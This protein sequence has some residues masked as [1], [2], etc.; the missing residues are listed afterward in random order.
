MTDQTILAD[1]VRDLHR[2]ADKVL[3]NTDSQHCTAIALANLVKEA[4]PALP[5]PTLA[6][7]TPSK[8]AECKWMQADVENRRVRYVIANPFDDGN[9]AA[10]IDPDGDICWIPPVRVTPRPGL[11]RMEW[12][13]TEKPAPALP[14]GWRLADHK[15]DGRVIV[16][17]TTPN[18]DGRVYFVAPTGGTMGNACGLC[19]LDE[20]TFLGDPVSQSKDY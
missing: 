19:R 18:R 7:M 15:E 11:P 2:L 9:E 17:N 3:A 13:G 5:L 4:A 10:L 6:D 14:E 12:P 20:L 1:N 8:R 16:T